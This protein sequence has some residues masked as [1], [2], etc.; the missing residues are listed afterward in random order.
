MVDVTERYSKG[1]HIREALQDAKAAVARAKEAVSLQASPGTPK[2]PPVK[3]SKPSEATPEPSKQKRKLSAAG[4][5]AIQEAARRRWAQKKEPTAKKDRAPKKATP[6]RKKTTLKKATLITPRTMRRS[7]R[8]R[9]RRLARL[10][11]QPRLPSRRQRNLRLKCPWAFS[12]SSPARRV[13]DHRQTEHPA[14]GNSGLSRS[15]T[16]PVSQFLPFTA[17]RF[18]G[19]KGLQQQTTVSAGGA[20]LPCNRSGRKCRGNAQQRRSRRALAPSPDQADEESPPLDEPHRSRCGAC[21]RLL[22]RW[23]MGSIAHRECPWS[24]WSAAYWS[25]RCTGLAATRHRPHSCCASRG[26]RYATK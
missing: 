7:R 16:A 18:V 14:G 3:S 10:L 26:I 21:S 8:Q 15:F 24:S 20:S 19:A 2:S 4:R 25:K 6:A 13:F 9:L 17:G 23:L 5:R 22:V 1:A 11:R 12:V